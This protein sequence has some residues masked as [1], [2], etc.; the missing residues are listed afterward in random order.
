MKEKLTHNPGGDPEII[1]SKEFFHNVVRVFLSQST[2]SKEITAQT[3]LAN[4]SFTQTL[5]IKKD[6]TSNNPGQI[7]PVGG[8]ID[9]EDRKDMVSD[10]IIKG[11]MREL[12]EE[13]HLVP[14]KIHLIKNGQNYRFFHNHTN[15]YKDNNSAFVVGR[16]LSKRFDMPYP[17]DIKEDRIESFVYLKMSEV[18]RLLSKGNI[19]Y[20]GEKLNILDSLNPSESERKKTKTIIDD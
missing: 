15:Q 13:T 8:K 7:M 19:E 16:L 1:Q 4:I 3:D 12:I 11:A 10:P 9:A 14:T 18:E 6:I 2:S 17:I 5:F 20:R